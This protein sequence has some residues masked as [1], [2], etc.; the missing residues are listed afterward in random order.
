MVI[1]HSLYFKYFPSRLKSWNLFRIFFSQI[2]R[3]LL[4]LVPR[5]KLFLSFF[6]LRETFLVESIFQKLKKIPNFIIIIII[7]ATQI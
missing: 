3:F 5:N 4:L 1:E 6:F 7:Y 2:W